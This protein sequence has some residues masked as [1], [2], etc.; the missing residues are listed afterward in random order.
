MSEQSGA[1]SP[2]YDDLGGMHAPT[3]R[4]RRSYRYPSRLIDPSP[5]KVCQNHIFDPQSGW[6][7][8]GTRDDGRLAPGS[9][10]EREANAARKLTP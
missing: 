3:G 6:C 9:P 10:A 7:S 8:C 5:G 4:R 1:P 2:A